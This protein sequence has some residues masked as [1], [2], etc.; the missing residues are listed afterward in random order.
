MITKEQKREY[1]REYLKKNREKRLKYQRDFYKKNRARISEKHKK[2]YREHKEEVLENSRKWHLENK[3]KHRKANR[4]Y[5]Y[6]HRARF[7]KVSRD[8]YKKNK[9]E[10]RKRVIKKKYG[11]DVIEYEKLVLAQK[12]LCAICKNSERVKFKG[13]LKELAVDHNHRT[14]KVRG[15]LCHSCN[16]AIGALLDNP[17]LFRKAAEYLEN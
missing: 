2:Y 8:W 12:N 5:M 11:L 4:E 6:K 1:D 15:L 16:L 9:S 13:R 17:D 14:G 10:S 3:E 7:N